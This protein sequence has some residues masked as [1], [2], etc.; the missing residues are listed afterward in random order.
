[1]VIGG[2]FSRLVLSAQPGEE[3]GRKVSLPGFLTMADHIRNRAE[4]ANTSQPGIH[5]LGPK[6]STAAPSFWQRWTVNGPW[7]L[8]AQP[9]RLHWQLSSV[10]STLEDYII[11]D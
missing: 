10:L 7:I 9:P 3:H 2:S 11:I 4:A 1:M 5:A 6:Q 8:N